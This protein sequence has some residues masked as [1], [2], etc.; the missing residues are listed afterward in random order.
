MP[1]TGRGGCDEGAEEVFAAAADL[2]EPLDE[3][4]DFLQSG[5]GQNRELV[6]REAALGGGLFRVRRAGFARPR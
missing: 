5:A 2:L 1:L 3:R 6:H 4:D